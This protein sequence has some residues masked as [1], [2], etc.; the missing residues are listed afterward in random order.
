MENIAQL[1]KVPVSGGGEGRRG[2]FNRDRGAV[3]ED[4]QVPGMVGRSHNS[5]NVLNATKLC[6]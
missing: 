2:V 5:V 3:W 6:T 1:S 4:E